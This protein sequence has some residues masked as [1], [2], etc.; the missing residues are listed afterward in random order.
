[1]AKS[2]QDKRIRGSIDII[3]YANMIALDNNITI[4][5]FQWDNGQD[6]SEKDTHT[7]CIYTES[8]NAFLEMSDELLV[9]YLWHEDTEKIND[10]VKKLILSFKEETE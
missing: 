2:A 9:N 1:M 10:Q 7:F 8:N 4:T 6:I 3:D 5:R